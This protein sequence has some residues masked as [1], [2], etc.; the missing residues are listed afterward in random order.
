MSYDET[1]VGDR[2]VT[3]GRT[4]TE[5]D[6]VNFAGVSGDFNRLHTDATAMTGSAF[7]ER[8]AHG[9]LVFSIMTGL[10]WQARED[11]D[12]VVAFY[13]VDD[14]R[15]RAPTTVGDTV[16]VELEVADKRP[17]EHPEATGIVSYR[18]EVKTADDA[19]VLSCTLLS[20]LR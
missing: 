10:L 2:L 17:T 4:V 20:L 13:G 14:L 16:R 18:A 19:V 7:G 5:A 3:A 11:G 6:L 1:T 12:A 9:A 8:I 15:F